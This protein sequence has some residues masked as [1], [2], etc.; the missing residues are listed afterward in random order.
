MYRYKARRLLA[1]LLDAETLKPRL[2]FNDL[3]QYLAAIKMISMFQAH[4]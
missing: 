2:S 4:L 3:E 1:L